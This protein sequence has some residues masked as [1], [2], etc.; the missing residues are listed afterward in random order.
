MT[1]LNP[2]LLKP[3][4]GWSKFC[5]GDFSFPVSYVTDAPQDILDA[6]IDNVKNNVSTI[7]DLD[8]E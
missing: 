5:I 8:G 1:K 3:H 2:V 7:V 4:Y 6:L